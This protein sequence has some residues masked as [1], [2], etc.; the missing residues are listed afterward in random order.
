MPQEMTFG[1]ALVSALGE[2][3]EQ[4]RREHF[5]ST[6]KDVAYRSEGNA[7]AKP[8]LLRVFPVKSEKN[9]R[10]QADDRANQQTAEAENQQADSTQNQSQHPEWIHGAAH[11]W[12]SRSAM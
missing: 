8:N 12:H 6:K 4:D 9:S 5:A 3:L 11:V 2:G 7:E 1:E 10:E